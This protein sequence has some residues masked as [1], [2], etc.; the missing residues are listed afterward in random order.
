MFTISIVWNVLE[1]FKTQYQNHH[2]NDAGEVERC[3]LFKKSKA[4]SEKSMNVN[5]VRVSDEDGFLFCS[6]MIKAKNNIKKERIWTNRVI[7]ETMFETH[8]EATGH[9]LPVHQ[10]RNVDD[11]RVHTCGPHGTCVDGVNSYSCYCDPGFQKTK[12]DRVK[13]DFIHTTNAQNLSCRLKASEFAALTTCGSVSPV[14]WEKSQRCVPNN[15]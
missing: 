6:M 2:A 1:Q 15:V 9:F 4:H 12:V 7:N 13:L 3:G 5:D 8:C 10:C 14:Q 11:C